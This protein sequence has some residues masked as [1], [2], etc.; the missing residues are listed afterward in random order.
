[1][2]HVALCGE[3]RV[4]RTFLL[5]LVTQNELDHKLPWEDPSERQDP[6]RRKGA[7][8]PDSITIGDHSQEERNSKQ[9]RQKTH[10]SIWRQACP[11][12][13]MKTSS[14]ARS[15]C[16]SKQKHWI[17]LKYNPAKVEKCGVKQKGATDKAGTQF[18]ILEKRLTT[19]WQW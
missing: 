14:P 9:V 5:L 12:L 2:A 16:S 18:E 3:S 11:R 6:K 15:L 19:C 4:T 1:M 10:L 17:L 13:R 8:P 7:C